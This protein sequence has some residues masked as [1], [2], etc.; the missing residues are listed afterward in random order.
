MK[1]NPRNTSQQYQLVKEFQFNGMKDF[2]FCSQSA[3][4]ANDY[5]NKQELDIYIMEEDTKGH[6][7]KTLEFRIVYKRESVYLLS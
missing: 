2:V 5:E 1:H 4:Q 3:N 7:T 6:Q